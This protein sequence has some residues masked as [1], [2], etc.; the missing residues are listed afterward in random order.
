LRS[1]RLVSLAGPLANV[2]QAVTVSAIAWYTP[3]LFGMETFFIMGFGLLF[4]LMN[5]IPIRRGIMRS[6]GW[7]VFRSDA[8]RRMGQATADLIRVND[9]LLSPA[10]PSEWPTHLVV[11]AEE[12]LW[13]P[14]HRVDTGVDPGV[15]AGYLLYYHYADQGRW[16]EAGRAISRATDLQRPHSRQAR[17]DRLPFVDLTYAVHLALLGN[18]AQA[19]Q[20]ALQRIP[21]RSPYRRLPRASAAQAAMLL[22][23][24]RPKEAIDHAQTAV[25]RAK[26]LR[27]FTNVDTLELEWWQQLLSTCVDAHRQNDPARPSVAGA[28]AKAVG[29]TAAV[30][31]AAGLLFLSLGAYA[32]ATSDSEASMQTGTTLLVSLGVVLGSAFWIG[33]ETNRRWGLSCA[34]LWILAFPTYV[35]QQSRGMTQPGTGLPVGKFPTRIVIRVLLVMSLMQFVLAGGAALIAN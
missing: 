28:L 5:L 14:S 25:R 33:R 8:A 2:L 9:L 30:L 12:I 13:Q 27:K 16:T 18:N 19:A 4:G 32:S 22:I 10:R 20:D 24:G 15:L 35:Y 17:H 11:Q 23:E 31:A 26:R 3:I 21:K 7:Y 29:A 6:D 1:W 34:L